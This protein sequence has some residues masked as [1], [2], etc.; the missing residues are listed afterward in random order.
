MD[1]RFFAAMLLSLEWTQ[2]CL[3][4]VQFSCFPVLLTKMLDRLSSAIVYYLIGLI[5][6]ISMYVYVEIHAQRSSMEDNDYIERS[7]F[8]NPLL[9]LSGSFDFLAMV[10]FSP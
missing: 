5:L 1:F 4:S 9:F 7:C 3:H 10:L 2:L 6:F 8:V